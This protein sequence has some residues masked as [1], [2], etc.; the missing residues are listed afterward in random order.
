MKS[1]TGGLAL[2]LLGLWGGVVGQAHA[3]ADDAKGWNARAAAAYLDHE[4]EWWS[5]WPAAARDRGTFCVSCHTVAPYALGRPALAAALGEPGPSPAAKKLFDNVATRVRLWNE[6]APFY[7]DQTRGLPKTSESRGTESVLNALVLAAR[8][9]QLGTLG[10]DTRAAFANM[11]ALQMRTGDLDG[12]WAWLNFH[13]EPWESSSSPY[14]G[15]AMAAL[16]VGTAPEG[17]AASADARAGL[18]RLRAF[19]AAGFD[20]Q[21]LFNK[22]TTLLAAERL[23]GLV[24]AAAREAT[25]RDVL[26]RQRP[27]GG[28]SLGTFGNFARVDNT[29]LDPDSDGYATALAVLAL[30]HAADAAAQAARTRGLAWLAANQDPATGR[31]R[32]VSLNKQRDPASDPARFM[33]DAAT[34]YAA[35]ALAGTR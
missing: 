2:L 18:D 35:L 30:R 25:V 13:Y 33:N 9:R 3:T 34:A 6:V 11:W 15:A 28:W 31:W 29:P 5:T 20:R 22:L 4:I 12:A 26:G 32:A 14:F 19:I 1:V 17:Y 27:D 21:N 16:A 23:D 10:G 7:P 8:D 24:S